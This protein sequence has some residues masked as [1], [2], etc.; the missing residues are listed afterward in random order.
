MFFGANFRAPDLNWKNSRE[1]LISKEPVKLV[2]KIS[3]NYAK[4]SLNGLT[5]TK[6]LRQ[7]HDLQ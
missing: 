4:K 1:A 6:P 5:L 7:F 2:V 3:A